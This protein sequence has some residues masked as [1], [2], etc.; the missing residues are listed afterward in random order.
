MM[1][2]QI[3]D[4]IVNPFS[5]SI[6]SLTL[7]L[8]AAARG[9]P[10]IAVV[11]FTLAMILSVSL[12]LITLLL[13]ILYHIFYV[14]SIKI[15]T[16]SESVYIRARRAAFGIGI[17]FCIFAR[18]DQIIMLTYKALKWYAEI[19]YIFKEDAYEKIIL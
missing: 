17:I 14:I 3:S 8:S 16:A 4:R 5:P 10:S 18:L 11:A 7:C 15:L 19:Y 6:Q 2:R 1:L 12:I 13:N 9:V